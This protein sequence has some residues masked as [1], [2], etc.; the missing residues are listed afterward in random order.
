MSEKFCY[1]SEMEPFAKYLIVAVLML[2]TYI[3]GIAHAAWFLTRK[4]NQLTR[5]QCGPAPCDEPSVEIP[6]V[7]FYQ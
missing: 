5:D 1:I 6:A 7:T 3:I 2:L 4:E